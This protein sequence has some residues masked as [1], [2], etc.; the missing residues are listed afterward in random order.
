M[1]THDHNQVMS[2]IGIAE[3]KAHLSQHLKRVRRGGTITVVDRDTPVAQ[4]VSYGADEP[5]K[6][7]RRT[8]KPA[9]LHLPPRANRPTDSLAVLLHDRL[10]R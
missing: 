8:R 5:L 3:L 10:K 6:V 7:R 1:T 9:D 4:I 2:R